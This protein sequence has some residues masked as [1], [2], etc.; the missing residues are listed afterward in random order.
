MRRIFLVFKSSVMADG[1]GEAGGEVKVIHTGH[2]V[3]AI[4]D[5]GNFL[6]MFE[7]KWS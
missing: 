1:E 2:V 6:T 5:E 4:V 3:G 7:S